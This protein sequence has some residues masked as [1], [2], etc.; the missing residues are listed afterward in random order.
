MLKRTLS[1]HTGKVDDEYQHNGTCGIVMF[2]EPLAGWRHAE[3][4]P[5]RAK[6]I[7]WLLDT[8]YPAAP[9]VILVMDNLNTHTIFSLYETFPPTEAFRLAQKVELHFTP[10]HGNWLDST[11]LEL[12]ALTAQCLGARCISDRA[13]LNTELSAWHTQRNRKRKGVDWQFTTANARTKLK[14]LYPQIIE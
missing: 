2:T 7:K 8:Q 6:Q 3:A 13:T 12:S 10:K 9:K 14:R 11:E 5:R 4:L 1:G